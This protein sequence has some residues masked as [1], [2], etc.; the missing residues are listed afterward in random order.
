MFARNPAQSAATSH[1]KLARWN[2]YHNRLAS[3]HLGGRIKARTLD[4]FQRPDPT[5]LAILTASGSAAAAPPSSQALER[6]RRQLAI[7]RCK[8]TGSTSHPCM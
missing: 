1:G 8:Q 5:G 6:D 4:G 3:V 2:L 7:I